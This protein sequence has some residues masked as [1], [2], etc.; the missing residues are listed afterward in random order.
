MQEVWKWANLTL[1]FVMEL[2]A[3]A[4]LALWGWKAADTTPVKLLLAVGAPVLA[5]SAWGLFAA[6]NG[7]FDQPLLAVVTKVVVFGG[8]AAGL[9]AV[10]YR[11]AAVVFV[12][13]L[14]TN[15][16]AIRLGHLTP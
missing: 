16:L 8:A 12:A 2:A 6:P 4:A 7:T 11:A 15:L 3:F 1:A 13:V 10:N 9:W 14:V 5:V